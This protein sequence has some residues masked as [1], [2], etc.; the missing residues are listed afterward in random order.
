ME[1]IKIPKLAKRL[2][3]HP[4]TLY[5]IKRRQSSPSSRLA[6]RLEP[7]TGVSRLKWLYPDE[8]GDPWAAARLK[9]DPG[10]SPWP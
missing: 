9:A 2:G 1:T 5:R 6:K 3:V 7:L 8:Y 4:D 10:A